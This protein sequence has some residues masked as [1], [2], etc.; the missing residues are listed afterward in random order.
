MKKHTENTKM[1]HF[2]GKKIDLPSLK[3]ESMTEKE[4]V[5][6]STLY[7]SEYRLVYTGHKIQL[8]LFGNFRSEKD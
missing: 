1:G 7:P 6:C 8:K 5:N 2:L 4:I 3:P